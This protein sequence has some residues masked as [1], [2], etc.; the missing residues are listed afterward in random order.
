MVEDWVAGIARAD[1]QQQRAEFAERV[2]QDERRRAD[3]ERRR[4]ME[5]RHRADQQLQRAEQA[6]SNERRRA[7]D[8]LAELAR[9]KAQLSRRHA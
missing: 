2:V 9:L 7:N 8:A 3:M 1:E 5:E 6:R 4:R